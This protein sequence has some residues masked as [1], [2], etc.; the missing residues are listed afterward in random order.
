MEMIALALGVTVFVC[1]VLLL[2]CWIM[3]ARKQPYVGVSGGFFLLG[4]CMLTTGIYP[5]MQVVYEL[6]FNNRLGESAMALLLKNLGAQLGLVLFVQIILTLISFFFSKIISI[7]P[8]QKELQQVFL[9]G[10]ILLGIAFLL[11]EPLFEI[12]A[13]LI[14][15][16]V[17]NGFN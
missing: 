4:I 5:N 11:K 17:S 10:I 12:G 8:R 14:D 9:S 2:Y 16:G 3:Y 15:T 1:L 6:F 13:S 7:D